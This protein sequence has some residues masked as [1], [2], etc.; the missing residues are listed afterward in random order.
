MRYSSPS[1]PASISDEVNDGGMES[2]SSGTDWPGPENQ[3][4]LEQ[5]DQ[6]D[7]R[8]DDQLVTLDKKG[9]INRYE[10]IAKY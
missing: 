6:F 8:C 2:N 5:E 9:E 3:L 1:I 7:L 10:A 4:G